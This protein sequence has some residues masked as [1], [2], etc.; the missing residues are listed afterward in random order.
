MEKK[1]ARLFLYNK[2]KILCHSKFN[3]ESSVK[4]LNTDTGSC[5]PAGGFIRMTSK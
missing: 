1:I 3:L 4:Y 2:N 5:P